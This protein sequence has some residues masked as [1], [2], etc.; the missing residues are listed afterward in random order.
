M[1]HRGKEN[2][3]K[4]VLEARCADLIARLGNEGH[5]PVLPN[6]WKREIN[7]LEAVV[8]NSKDLE[9]VKGLEF[10]HVFLVL[11]KELYDEIEHGFNGSGQSR[12]LARRLLRIPFSRAKDSL[13]SFVV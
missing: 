6:S 1:A 5:E 2:Q 12:Y 3:R 11:A 9:L 8:I 7:G 13:V 4:A 10:Q